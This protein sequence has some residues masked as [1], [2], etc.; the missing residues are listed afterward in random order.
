VARH[1]SGSGYHPHLRAPARPLVP[2][3]GAS[4]QWLDPHEKFLGLPAQLIHLDG[5]LTGR[6]PVWLSR[7]RYGLPV[8]L[9]SSWLTP[10]TFAGTPYLRADRANETLEAFLSQSGVTAILLNTVPAAGPFRDSLNGV[11]ARIGA[12]IAELHRWTRASLTLTGRFEDWFESNFERKR[13]KE[14]RRLRA[15]LGET[16]NLQ[17]QS[18]HRGEA[19]D[20]WIDE[21][22]ALEAAGWKGR[23]GTAIANSTAALAC[24]RECLRALHA[25][26]RL[27]FWKLALDGRPLAMMFAMTEADHAWLGKIA[28]DE[29]FAKFSPG[30]LLILDATADLFA[31][32]HITIVDSCAIPGHPMIDHLWRDRLAFCDLLIGRPGMSRT[33]FA[34]LRTAELTRRALRSQLKNLLYRVQQRRQS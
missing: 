1:K 8:R 30:V 17:S 27:R 26:G 14:F 15:R 19:L 34:V 7:W 20:P 23:R 3:L 25:E 6:F 9:L 29:E 31:D 24:L 33:A 5:E 16:G 28:Y 21:L 2:A 32:P 10:L 4:A 11:C 22:T 12:P 13:K 18:L